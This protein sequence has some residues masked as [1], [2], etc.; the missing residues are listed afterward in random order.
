[1]KKKIMV[2]T[3]S[4]SILLLTGTAVLSEN[5]QS[6]PNQNNA[7]IAQQQKKTSQTPRYIQ[8]IGAEFT[9]IQNDWAHEE[10]LEA[11]AKGFVTGY[12]DFTF[13]PDSSVSKLETLVMII[14]ALG[15]SEEAQD[16]DL[17]DEQAA[18]L[19]K[20]PDW[21]QNYMALALEKGIVTTE[22]LSSFNPQQAAKRYEVCMYM[23]RI[24]TD[25][26]QKEDLKSTVLTDEDQIPEANRMQVRLMLMNGIV[27][28][29]P[30]GKFQPMKAVKRNELTTMLNK[31]DE[32]CLQ[33]FTSATVKGTVKGVSETEGGYAISIETEDG[34][35]VVVNT[36]AQSKLI[37]KG[38]LLS[39]NANIESS[40]EVKIL[41]D[42]DGGAV[43]VRFMG[44]GEGL[45]TVD[46]V[47]GKEA[48]D[49]LNKNKHGKS[50]KPA[51]LDEL[52]EIDE[53]DE[54]DTI[55]KIKGIDRIKNIDKVFK[56]GKIDTTSFIDELDELDELNGLPE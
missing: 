30:D 25:D 49:K 42:Q 10:V 41:L 6:Q 3:L 4:L 28:G 13:R 31:L 54:I 47:D 16:Y 56:I 34:K 37:Y 8:E 2:A 1:M 11:R 21:G 40:L 18:L 39:T 27:S 36:S 14:N 20:I 44:T 24:L 43:L 7:G 55:D 15:L 45:A 38:Q 33:C 52:D 50:N 29:Y 12:A 46:D 23:S 26:D 51:L 32:N 19:A 9:D 17:S 53:I 5:P 48:Q 35:T 22:E